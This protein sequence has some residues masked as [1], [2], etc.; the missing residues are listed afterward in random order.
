MK[1]A[2]RIANQ[3]LCHWR[4]ARELMFIGIY[5][6][7]KLSDYFIGGLNEEVFNH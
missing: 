4:G 1:V 3:R 7:H 6:L 5:L 2:T